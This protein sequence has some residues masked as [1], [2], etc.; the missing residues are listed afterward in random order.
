MKKFIEEFKE[1][2]VGG[3]LLDMAVG[4]IVGGAFS[5]I[6]NSLVTDIFTPIIGMLLGS[7]TDFSNLKLGQ[8]MIGNFINAVISFLIT[9]FCLFTVV[10]AINKAKEKLVKAEEEAP[11]EEPEPSDEVKLLTTIAEELKKLN[12]KK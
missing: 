6:I 7:Q 12:K 3:N 9:A 4:V 1:F 2:A 8:I 10:K 11:A 5:N